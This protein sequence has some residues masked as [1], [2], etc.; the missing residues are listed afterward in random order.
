[1]LIPAYIV[2][3]NCQKKLRSET[4]RGGPTAGRR[5]IQTL[6]KKR[7]RDYNNQYTMIYIY[8]NASPVSEVAGIFG[9]HDHWSASI[10]RTGPE[11]IT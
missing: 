11:T 1:L 6:K 4:D 10:R 7:N 8:Q 3:Y 9:L 5:R 2:V